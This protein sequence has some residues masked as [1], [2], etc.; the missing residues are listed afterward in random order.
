MYSSVTTLVDRMDSHDLSDLGVIPWSCPV[1]CFG[2]LTT[3]TVATVGINPSNREFLDEFGAELDNGARRLP[4]LKS[5]GL[6]R[7]ADMEAT[8]LRE[9]I[10]ACLGYF[11]RNPYDRWFTTLEHILQKAGVTF[12][13]DNPSACHL[14]LVPYATTVKWGLLPPPVRRKLMSTNADALGDLL[15]ESSV[16]TLILNGQSV[17]SQFQ[18][19]NGVRLHATPKPKWALART[20]SADVMGMSYVG[21]TDQ[22]GSVRLARPLRVVG[23]NHN[24]QSSF[25]VTRAVI[26][27]IASWISTTVP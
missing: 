15:R 3:A 26:D 6:A 25:G 19:V 24:L 9:L 11:R 16:E 8:H 5:L 14:D 20:G 12:Y 4:T 23:S 17:V 10:S 22:I 18:L 7:W 1:P 13:G 27:A 21:G 2:D